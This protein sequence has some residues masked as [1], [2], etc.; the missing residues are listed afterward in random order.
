MFAVKVN[1]SLSDAAPSTICEFGI[2]DFDLSLI[3]GS[4]FSP[5][6]NESS[7]VT[8]NFAMLSGINFSKLRTSESWLKIYSDDFWTTVI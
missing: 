5:K 6:I 2:F 1:G 8:S 4:P 7:P 3:S